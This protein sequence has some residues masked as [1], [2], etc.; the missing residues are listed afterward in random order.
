MSAAGP[1]IVGEALGEVPYRFDGE[2]TLFLS[3]VYNKTNE[4]VVQALQNEP[5]S[6]YERPPPVCRSLLRLTR[7]LRQVR[8]SRGDLGQWPELSCP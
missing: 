4:M 7:F 5:E 2:R 3:E 6:W 8:R 1:L